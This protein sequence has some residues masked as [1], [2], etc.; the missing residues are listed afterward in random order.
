M[1][2]RDLVFA[3]VTIKTKEADK[4]LMNFRQRNKSSV[5]WLGFT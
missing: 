4:N 2:K 5:D 3:F 1:S